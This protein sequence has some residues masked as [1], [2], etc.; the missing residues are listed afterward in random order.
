M[1]PKHVLAAAVLPLALLAAGCSDDEE[2]GSDSTDTTE[3]A[4][5]TT[6]TAAAEDASMPVAMGPAVDLEKSDQY[7]IAQIASGLPQTQTVTRLVIQAG[8]VGTLATGGPFTVFAPVNEA[9][10]AIPPETLIDIS[11]DTEQLTTVLTLHVVPGVYTSED[12]VELDGQSLETA[13]GGKLLV[14]VNGDEILV[15][16]APVAIP[17]ITASNGVVHAVTSVI[18]APNG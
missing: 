3:A 15:G 13:Q 1:K 7:N 17:D 12:L 5:E 4:A 2:S 11:Q 10:D 16:G 8:L 6:T 9:F 18:T 14:E